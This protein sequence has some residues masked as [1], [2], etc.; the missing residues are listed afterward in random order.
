MT[1]HDGGGKPLSEQR[2]D[3]MKTV[4]WRMRRNRLGP[5]AGLFLA[6]M[7]AFALFPGVFATHDP[8]QQSLMNS[9]QGSSSE[10]WLGTDHLGRDTWSR[11]VYGTRISLQ[12]GL[13]AVS[14]AAVSGLLVG[15]LAVFRGG[16]LDACLM[17]LADAIWSLPYIVLALALVTIRGPGLFNIMLAIAVVYMPGF[18]RLARALTISTKSRDFVQA[19]IASGMS[20]T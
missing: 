16:W 12:V 13:V 10:H 18:A 1:E 3:T 11:I 6:V 9:L 5:I 20:N 7:V 2:R 17:R 14:I 8:L 4:L 19:A 15:L